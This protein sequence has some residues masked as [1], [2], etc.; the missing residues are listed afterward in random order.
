MTGHDAGTVK[1]WDRYDTVFVAGAVPPAALAGA[2]D[3]TASTVAATAATPVLAIP[4]FPGMVALPLAMELIDA[5]DI[6]V[7]HRNRGRTSAVSQ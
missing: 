5:D 3:M 4:D 6:D 7:H 2:P 1:V